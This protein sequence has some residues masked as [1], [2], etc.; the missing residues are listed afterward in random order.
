MGDLVLVEEHPLRCLSRAGVECHLLLEEDPPD[1]VQSFLQVIT[2][3]TLLG[4]LVV[5]FQLERFL[6]KG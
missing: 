5:W 1:L 4:A 6:L 2:S 3:M